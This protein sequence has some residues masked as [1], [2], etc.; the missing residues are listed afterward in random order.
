LL[1][2]TSLMKDVFTFD[3]AN[4][5]IEAGAGMALS[6]LDAFLKEHGCFFPL[7]AFDL[8]ALTI[9]GAYQTNALG[10][11]SGSFGQIKDLVWVSSLKPRPSRGCILGRT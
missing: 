7:D 9:G 8:D 3:R 6:S 10:G 4:L 11:L 5:T 2:K 1:V